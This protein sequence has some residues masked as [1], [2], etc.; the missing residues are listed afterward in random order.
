MF[1]N[2]L[3]LFTK[4]ASRTAAKTK[5]IL[6]SSDLERT[7]E[8]HRSCVIS[9]RGGRDPL[10]AIAVSV[11]CG[12][13]MLSTLSG[14]WAKYPKSLITNEVERRFK[15]RKLAKWLDHI[16]LADALVSPVRIQSFYEDKDIYTGRKHLH[17]FMQNKKWIS[18]EK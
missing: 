15:F 10:V 6:C 8:S 16:K 5:D 13:F 9:G 2:F 7:D 12:S 3:H 17:P 4:K 18:T 1:L 14:L 11:G